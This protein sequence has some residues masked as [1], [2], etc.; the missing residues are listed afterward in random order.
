MNKRLAL[1][2]GAVV[3]YLLPAEPVVSLDRAKATG[4]FAAGN[5][6]RRP[7]GVVDSHVRPLREGAPEV[8]TGAV[9]REM[10]LRVGLDRQVCRVGE[11][12]SLIVDVTGDFA[13]DSLMPLALSKHEVLA[14]RFQVYDDS[15]NTLLLENGKRFTYR[16]RPLAAGTQELPPLAAAFFDL[17]SDSYRTVYSQAVPLQ[18]LPGPELEVILEGEGN[19]AAS[20]R[21]RDM[22]WPE[23][24]NP[25]AAI[26][27]SVNGS[28]AVPIPLAGWLAGPVL[29]A[30]ACLGR[31][32]F[33]R[34]P[35]RRQRLR[36]A[37]LVLAGQPLADLSVPELHGAVKQYLLDGWNMPPSLLTPVEVAKFLSAHGLPSRLTAAWRDCLQH[38][39]S[40][41][42]QPETVDHN[43]RE[44]AARLARL[45]QG[46]AES[47]LNKRNNLGR[48]ALIAAVILWPG[49]AAAS[50]PGLDAEIRD[51]LRGQALSVLGSA[52]KQED[53]LAAAA[54]LAE[55][56][57]SPH[58]GPELLYNLGTALL[59][60]GQDEAALAALRRAER[61]GGDMPGLRR[62]L[63]LAHAAYNNYPQPFLP[64]YRWPL[65]PHFAIALPV[66]QWLAWLFWTISWLGLAGAQIPRR[67]GQAIGFTLVAAVAAILCAISV[68]FSWLEETRDRQEWPRLMRPAR[69]YH[70][71]F[72]GGSTG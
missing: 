31:Y 19:D 38:L 65:Y 14:G 24:A 35:R 16:I 3:F 11:P 48:Y 58:A 10:K 63:A 15:V 40:L 32:R 34:R 9:G 64:W 39:D 60:A 41:R 44:L 25:P 43:Q 5:R 30:M 51:F 69:D 1:A 55:F 66:R 7:P 70:E 17:S 12:L 27:L 42:Y 67:R 29:F 62:N 56:D 52:E 20:W 21:W 13:L 71:S 2:V 23:Q 4:A 53:F 54:I 36:R 28:P 46:T 50:C 61:W 8:F 33:C 37:G 22:P 59:L 49:F 57:I 47:S 18:V 26:V 72:T 68:G 6:Q 45:V